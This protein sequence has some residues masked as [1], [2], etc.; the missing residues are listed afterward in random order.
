MA[1]IN[2]LTVY[3]KHLLLQIPRNGWKNIQ[4]IHKCIQY[5]IKKCQ[6]NYDYL[7]QYNM[8]SEMLT[9]KQQWENIE[10][11]P[12]PYLN[13]LVANGW[14]EKQDGLYRQIAKN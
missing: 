8:G 14:I 13:E 1:T 3:A 12:Y 9:E 5:M 11:D 2:D 10:S 4:Y 6:D 7:S